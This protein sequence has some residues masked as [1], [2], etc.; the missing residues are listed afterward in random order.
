MKNKE[1]I[2]PKQKDINLMTFKNLRR[3]LGLKNIQEDVLDKF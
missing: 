3:Q 1:K 2:E